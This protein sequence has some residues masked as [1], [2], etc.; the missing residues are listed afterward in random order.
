MLRKVL[1]LSLL[2][3]VPLL[4]G[5][6][7]KGN[8]TLTQVCHYSIHPYF[9]HSHSSF[10]NH[11]PRV[12]STLSFRCHIPWP[13]SQCKK[14]PSIAFSSIPRPPSRA[15]TLE[16][17]S[18]PEYVPLFLPLFSILTHRRLSQELSQPSHSRDRIQELCTVGLTPR[19]DPFLPCCLSSL[20]TRCFLLFAF[21]FLLFV[22]T[23][24]TI[25]CSTEQF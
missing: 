24:E 13:S 6:K 1:P 7:N 12:H 3:L 10:H 4:L 8:N 18:L 20:F 17:H 11:H 25:P 9:I 14:R 23:L 22:A 15:P 19:H 5:T 2:V 16:S 21:C